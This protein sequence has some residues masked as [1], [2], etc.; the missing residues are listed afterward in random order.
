[1]GNMKGGQTEGKIMKLI[2]VYHN[3]PTPLVRDEYSCC[4]EECNCLPSNVEYAQVILSPELPSGS[5]LIT[6]NYK[7]NN[8]Y[9]RLLF[10]I[11]IYACIVRQTSN[12]NHDK[13]AVSKTETSVINYETETYL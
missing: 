7:I 3:F 5:R 12:S 10:E 4:Q 8:N 9:L 13:M 1:M 11:F 6:L 2:V